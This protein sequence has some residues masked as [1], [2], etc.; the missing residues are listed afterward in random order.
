MLHSELGKSF[1]VYVS[2]GSNDKLVARY[3]LGGE[4]SERTWHL[5]NGYF[6]KL[7]NTD[8]GSQFLGWNGRYL[9]V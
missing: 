5:T 9:K 1:E 7:K 8:A 2:D 6:L 3:E 4:V